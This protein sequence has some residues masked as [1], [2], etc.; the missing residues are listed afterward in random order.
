M[1]LIRSP[2]KKG[3]KGAGI[4]AF[5][6]SVKTQ[7]KPTKENVGNLQLRQRSLKLSAPVS[8]NRCSSSVLPLSRRL[9]TNALPPEKNTPK[10]LNQT[11][12]ILLLVR[13][14]W[15]SLRFGG[16]YR[17]LSLGSRKAFPHRERTSFSLAEMYVQGVSTRKVTE[18]LQAL[19]GLRVSISQVSRA[20]AEL[21]PQSYV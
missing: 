16:G 20:V 1:H 12:S 5:G 17:F 19:C 9:L 4:L 3:K 14:A 6:V 13:L 11:L 8:M 18:V 15:T 7:L 2:A 10:A 21:D